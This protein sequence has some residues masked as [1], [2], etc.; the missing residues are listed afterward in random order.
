M[1]RRS[2]VFIYKNGPHAFFTVLFP[3]ML[4][5]PYFTV[6]WSCSPDSLLHKD[7]TGDSSLLP[8]WLL[9]A[10]SRNAVASPIP[11]HTPRTPRAFQNNAQP[12]MVT[13]F[14]LEGSHYLNWI[15]ISEKYLPAVS[16]ISK[17]EWRKSVIL[18]FSTP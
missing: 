3:F 13:I 2:L 12:S 5:F 10:P 4:S 16:K 1:G 17:G 18:L 15:I 8:H 7:A 9:L 14:S 11:I 6:Q